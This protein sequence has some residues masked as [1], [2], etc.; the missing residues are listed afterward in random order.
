MQKNWQR[1][2]IM[3]FTGES[4]QSDSAQQSKV[5][6]KTVMP[7]GAPCS[8]IRSFLFLGLLGAVRSPLRDGN[9]FR[10]EFKEA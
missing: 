3:Q 4:A 8:A 7:V 10:P 5:R 6:F 1:P 2:I 9:S